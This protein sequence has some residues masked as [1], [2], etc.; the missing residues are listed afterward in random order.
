VWNSSGFGAWK[1]IFHYCTVTGCP[2]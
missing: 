1:S 2:T